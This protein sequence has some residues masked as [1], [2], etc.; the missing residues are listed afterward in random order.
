M[1]FENSLR[2]FLAAALTLF[3]AVSCSPTKPEEL[4]RATEPE[5]AGPYSVVCTVGM[6]TDVVRNVAGDLASVEGIIG[7]GVDPHLYK[8]TRGDVVQLNQADVVFYNGLMLEGKMADVL[9]RVAGSGKPVRAVTEVIL[10]NGSYLMNKDDG[11]GHTDP[12][13]WMDV[14]GWMQAVPVVTATLSVYDPE[15]TEQYKANAD[16]Y[17]AQ[18]KALDAYAK[19]SLS[20]IP[21][22]QRVLITAHDAFNYMGRAYGIQVRGIQGISTESE[23]GVR[24]LEELVDFIVEMN[25]PAVFVE[26]SVADKN[27]RALVEGAKARGHAVII[28]GELFSDAMGE[29]GTY[30]GTY[31]GMIDH[32]VTTITNALGGTAKGFKGE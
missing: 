18:L 32:N 22:S 4:S 14:R 23:A 5:A 27:V 28:G 24:D 25:I 9:V 20:T 29:P 30:E 1:K 15:H 26:S 10:E 19:S 12:H 2:C 16:A 8:P 11:S 17:L 7:E 6:I 21:E 31:I 3:F 13:V